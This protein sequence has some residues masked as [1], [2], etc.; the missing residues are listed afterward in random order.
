MHL[1]PENDRFHFMDNSVMDRSRYLE[2]F[3]VIQ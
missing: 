3:E 2:F 1:G